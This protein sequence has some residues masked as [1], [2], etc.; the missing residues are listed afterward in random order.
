[1]ARTFS[2]NWYRVADLRLGLRPG[3]SIRLHTYRGEP[4]YV[5]HERAHAGYFRVNPDTYQFLARIRVDTTLNDIW[6]A[7]I[8]EAP[9]ETP[10]QEAVFE[11]ISA[12]Y[13]AN[14]I[15]VEGDVDEG[16]ILERFVRR[17]K[18]SLV[19]RMSELLFMRI[20]MLD[21]DPWLRKHSHGLEK[22][23]SRYALWPA[24]ALVLWAVVEFI[25]AGSQTLSQAR[26]I[27]QLNNLLLL[28]V[29]V[30][31]SH[32]LHELAHAAVCKHYGGEVRTMGIMLLLLTPLP[33]VDLSSSWTFRNR[34][35]RALV[36]SAGMLMD[37][38]VGAVATLVW[39]Y[40]PPGL[41]NE[42]AY[43]LMFST[44]VYTILFNINPLMRF[45][46]YY[47][48]SD[49]LQIPNLHEQSRQAFRRWWHQ[50][51]LGIAP[52]D[53]VS[54]SQTERFG[55]TVFF[56]GSNA[57]R[58][59]VM[60][61][62]VL[63]VA[64]QYFGVG[65]LVAF[66][67]V[68]TSFVMPLKQLLEPLRSP[69]FRFQQK[70]LLQRS[71]IVGVVLLVFVAAV[72]MPDSRVLEG[73]V[74]AKT[75]TPIFTESGGVVRRVLV[76]SGQWV[77][78]GDLLVELENPELDAELKAFQAQRAQAQ[79]QEAKSLTE[80]SVDLA[81]VRERLKSIDAATRSL[82]IQR[83]ALTQRAPHPGIWVET[84]TTYRQGDWLARGAEMGR[85]VDDRTH[86]FLGVI[87]QETA[88]AL[89]DMQLQG[90]RVRIE[91]ERDVIHETQS[92][93]LVPHSQ[94][95]L[96]SAALSP[97]AGGA[98]AVKTTDSS[99]TQAVEPFFLLRAEL[100]GEID[101]TSNAV[102]RH[103]RAGWIKIRLTPRPLAWQ[104][105]RGMTQFFQ[106]RYKL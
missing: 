50:R 94:S 102:V 69:L 83:A 78:L 70:R 43:N 27:L 45:D 53:E 81:P 84:D 90:S 34:Y 76:R 13:R 12:L 25:Q 46:G 80:S 68:M 85:V 2:D 86:V 47:I 18:K 95:T 82:E 4:W 75:N 66:A 15:Y 97:G 17:K 56:L 105:W 35:Q 14:L 49:L 6:R 71:A 28:Y 60:L 26:N 106:R 21:P 40:T 93:R 103:G 104:A 62:I 99:G 65:L 77:E 41:V 61:G 8:T 48:L 30:F 98:V 79:A 100:Q 19:A 96:P 91:G 16:K 42:L 5:L 92:V 89:V 73:V 20:P 44:V 72:P 58:L 51:V 55:L 1:M 67:L 31:A 9:E 87:R 33:Y 37:L 64:D 88:I 63:F 29:A 32:F 59:M 39:A 22:L 74:E 101:Q 3:V 10:G 23:L 24:A 7:A 38:L 52:L 57:Y 36:D 11:L 54:G